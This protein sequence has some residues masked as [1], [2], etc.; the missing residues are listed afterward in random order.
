MSPESL[1]SEQLGDQAPWIVAL[2]VSLWF[3]WRLW[4]TTALSTRAPDTT[5]SFVKEEDSGTG[6]LDFVLTLPI[7][8]LLVL[9]IV[10]MVLIINARI[11]V[12]YAAYTAARSAA[13]TVPEGL[14]DKVRRAAVTSCMPIA[15]S[16]SRVPFTLWIYLSTRNGEVDGDLSEVLFESQSARFLPL[17]LHS[18]SSW[19]GLHLSRVRGKA[20]YSFLATEVEITEEQSPA[21]RPA[22]TVTVTHQFYLDVPYAGEIFA[23]LLGGLV[24]YVFPIMPISDSYTMVLEE[25]YSL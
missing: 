8:M 23:R 25:K 20:A 6:M 16:L 19:R 11:M 5:R 17:F 13:V 18:P 12:S 9:L 15:P 4:R 24:G 10:Q 21:P 14:S 3:L 7:F 1:F 2:L 22:V